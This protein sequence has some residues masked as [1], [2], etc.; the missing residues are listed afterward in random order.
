VDVGD[1][2]GR[3]AGQHG[4]VGAA[5]EQMPGIQAQGDPGAVQDLLYLLAG[6]DHGA[7]VGMQYRPDAAARGQLGQPVEVG[8]Q[9]HPAVVVEQR[10]GVIALGA[11]DRRQDQDARA[12]GGVAVQEPV[13]LGHGVVGADVEEQGGEPADGLEVVL[14]Q[15]SGH[16]VGLAGQEAVG[17][18]LGGGQA[19]LAHLGQHP[20]GTELMAPAGHLAHAP[21]DG[22]AGD[23]GF[24]GRRLG[25]GHLRTSSIRTG[26]CS[27]SDVVQASAIQPASKASATVHG[28]GRRAATTS[29]KASSS[30]R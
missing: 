2:L 4:R 6:L 28:E 25:G 1:A 23:G 29:V 27:S 9:H 12:R 22:G 10:P 5:D 20:V 16:G 11:G 13:D 24:D 19:D 18:E 8:E 7:D 17:A 30:A 26:R 14:V 21:G 3:L 15:D